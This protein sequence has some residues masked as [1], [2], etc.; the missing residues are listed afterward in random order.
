M[1]LKLSRR[2]FLQSASLGCGALAMPWLSRMAVA[3]WE[4]VPAI[5]ARIQPP[6]FPKRDFDI[7]KYGAVGNGV[8]D[9]SEAIR[10]AIAACSRAGGGR[11]LVPAGDFLTGAIHLRSRVN[12]HLSAGATL[13]FHTDPRRYLPA[14]YTRWEGVECMNY[15]PFIYAFD[16]KDVAVTGAGTL[17]GQSAVQDGR[18]RY[19]RK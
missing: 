5:L 3:G 12:L 10:G 14:V 19:S 16:Q 7:T 4:D 18:Q 8:K 13:R 1:A 17:D 6:V 2:V 11:V 9:C 15:S